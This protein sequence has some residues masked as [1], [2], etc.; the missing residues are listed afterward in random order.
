MRK[1][2]LYL[3]LAVALALAGPTAVPAWAEAT[4]APSVTG[5]FNLI[6]QDG[7]PVTEASYAGRLRI[8]T[9][10]YT[11][12]PDVCPTTL[13]VMAA[14]IQRL[15]PDAARVIP[16]F[17]TVDPKR[18]TPARLKEYTAA[19]D[20]RFVGLS[21]TPEA[22]ARAAYEFRVRYHINPPEAGEPDIY[23]VDH[24]AGIY[25]MDGDGRFLAK[26][27]YQLEADDISE[28]V[29]AYLR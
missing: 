24:S 28:R 7:R 8:M 10:G 6:D 11:F 12:C 19:F 9:F 3:G 2:L 13:A 25:L 20:H 5:R 14:A 4:V 1:A 26:F 15:G 17:V 23:T 27:P 29:R 22:V 16:I 21:G 18:D